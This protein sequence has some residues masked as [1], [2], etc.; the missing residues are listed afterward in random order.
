MSFEYIRG[1]AQTSIT[2][3]AKQLYVKSFKIDIAAGD[4]FTSA[5]EYTLGYLPR[6]SQ[7]I[8]GNVI[9]PTAVSGG[10]VSAATITIKAGGQQI[11]A[12]MNV[13]AAATVTMGP[14]NFYANTAWTSTSDQVVTYTPTLTGAGA[15][16]GVMYIN[17]SYVA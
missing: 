17:I 5:T 8:T 16:A 12:L 15:T 3:P 1:Q 2:P 7:V 11:G 6:G 4:G 10:T 14:T 13:F 9:V